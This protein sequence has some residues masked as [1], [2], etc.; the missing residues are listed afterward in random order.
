MLH[1]VLP[2]F[3][4]EVILLHNKAHFTSIVIPCL[5]LLFQSWQLI[6][7]ILYGISTSLTAMI[8][9]FE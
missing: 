3:N 8:C 6:K 1:T 4:W 9:S 2:S 5:V 7:V